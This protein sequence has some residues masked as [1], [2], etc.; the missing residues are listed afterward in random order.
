MFIKCCFH[1]K[2]SILLQQISIYYDKLIIEHHRNGVHGVEVQ[3]VQLEVASSF[4]QANTITVFK[5]AK[6]R[7]QIHTVIIL[8]EIS[9]LMKFRSCIRVVGRL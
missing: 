4:T 7:G 8:W 2:I 9:S 5:I 6:G 3:K 1:V